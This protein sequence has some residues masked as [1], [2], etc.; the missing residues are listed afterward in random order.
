[1]KSRL[2]LTRRTLLA[3]AAAVVSAQPE[4]G[5]RAQTILPDK[6]L[7]IFV[8]FAPGGGADQMARVIAPQLERR[9]GRRVSVENRPGGTAAIPGELV[10]KGPKDG[11]MVAF[12]ASTTLASKFVVPNFPFDPLTDITPIAIAGNVP[13]GLAVSPRTGVTTLADYLKWLKDGDDSR[14]R[15]GN[16]SSS[17]FVEVFIKLIGHQ[18]DVTLEIVPYRGAQPMVS[19]MATGR[20]PAGVTAITS[21]LEHHRGGRVKLLLSSGRKRSAV[22]PDVPTAAELGYPNLEV[23]EWF[24]FFAAAGTPDPILTEWHTH[25]VAV[26]DD[27]EVKA[28]LVQLGFEVAP[29]TQ[30]EAKARVTSYLRDWKRRLELVGMHTTN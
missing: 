20:L 30:D 27:R 7:R 23:E 9:L 6:S 4:D 24:G 3:G 29:S 12:L 21:L 8:G 18:I 25:I 22:A 28:E 19:D 26:L 10:A 17:T 1:L 16:T 2:L 15:I 14:R 11:S 5:A 13:T